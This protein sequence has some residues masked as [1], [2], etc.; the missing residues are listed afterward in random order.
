MSTSLNG[1]NTGYAEAH[2]C[3]AIAGTAGVMNRE[4]RIDTSSTFGQLNR[5]TKLDLAEIDGKRR[6]GLADQRGV[7]VKASGFREAAVAPF[8]IAQIIKDQCFPVVLGTVP[9]RNAAASRYPMIS[10]L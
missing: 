4:R 5:K 7:E 1:G 6:C 2:A 10:N 9:D 8:G 3:L